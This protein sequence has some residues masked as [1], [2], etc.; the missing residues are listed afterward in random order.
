MIQECGESKQPLL[1]DNPKQGTRRYMSPE[2]LGESINM[3]S[4]RNIL[5]VDIYA[6]GLVMWEIT[7][8]CKDDCGKGGEGRGRGRGRGGEGRGGEE[9][10]REEED[11]N[12][13]CF[14]C[15]HLNFWGQ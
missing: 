11:V 5:K 15:K 7:K 2:V 3:R 10:G 1:P 14:V 4:F 13:P 9:G 6:M 8:R 12:F